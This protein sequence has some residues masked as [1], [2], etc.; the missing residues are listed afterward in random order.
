MEGFFPSPAGGWV[1]SAPRKITGCWNTEGLQKKKT[2]LSHLQMN[3][4][5]SIWGFVSISA[6]LHRETFLSGTLAR[7]KQW[8]LCVQE[9]NFYNTN[10]HCETR[11]HRTVGMT[12]GEKSQR[13]APQQCR[14]SLT[15]TIILPFDSVSAGRP[16]LHFSGA[17]A[18]QQMAVCSSMH[19]VLAYRRQ[20]PGWSPSPPRYSSMHH[21]FMLKLRFHSFRNPQERIPTTCTPEVFVCFAWCI[22]PLLK[23]WYAPNNS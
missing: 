5:C 21:F 19:T 10:G 17:S 11:C 20:A 16:E 13:A 15:E 3:S 1:T 4:W 12:L 7:P 18:M 9:V 22:C 14:Q 8:D 6:T 2:T 23:N